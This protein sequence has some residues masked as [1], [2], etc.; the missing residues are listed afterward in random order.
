MT[1]F[2]EKAKSKFNLGFI[3]LLIVGFNLLMVGEFLG[4]I[5]L[6]PFLEQYLMNTYWGNFLTLLS[7]AF[8][9]LVIIFWVRVIEKVL[10]KV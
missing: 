3:L 8:I 9:T 6:G 1:I 10:G 2:T 7:F 4:T 5:V